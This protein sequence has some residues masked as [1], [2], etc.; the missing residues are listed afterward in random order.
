MSRMVMQA[1]STKADL[2]QNFATVY[3]SNPGQGN[4][5]IANFSGHET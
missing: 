1:K 3:G 4:K 2:S 5:V